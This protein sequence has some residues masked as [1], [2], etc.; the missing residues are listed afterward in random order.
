[1]C[2]CCVCFA[3]CVLLACVGCANVLVQ[4]GMKQEEKQDENKHDEREEKK[5]DVNKHKEKEDEI[6]MKREKRER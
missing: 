6:S 5:Q 2:C 3:S 4:T 1:V